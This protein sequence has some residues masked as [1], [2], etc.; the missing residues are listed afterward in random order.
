MARRLLHDH[1]AE[2]PDARAALLSFKSGRRSFGA[3]N[4]RLEKRLAEI[5]TNQRAAAGEA[6][7][8]ARSGEERRKR[9][10]ELNQLV[11]AEEDFA[12]QNA[13]SDQELAG[14]FAARYGKYVPPPKVEEAEP[15][16]VE[17]P[18]RVRDAP[19]NPA[20]SKKAKR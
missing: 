13:V 10:E 18:V 3:F 17:N 4:P 8:A 15:P 19:L 2:E 14:H 11:Q 9:E 5:T 16:V 12:K 7:A 20:P 1:E 6:A